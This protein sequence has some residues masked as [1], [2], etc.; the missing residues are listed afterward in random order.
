M[1]L[2]R[3]SFNALTLNDGAYNDVFNINTVA[4][5]FELPNG[6]IFRGHPMPMPRPHI[7]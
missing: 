2:S 3:H 5:R 1:L 4:K 6:G 7:A